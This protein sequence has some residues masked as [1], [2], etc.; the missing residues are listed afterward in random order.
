MFGCHLSQLWLSCKQLNNWINLIIYQ[1]KKRWIVCISY[2]VRTW[3]EHCD[4]I[5]TSFIYGLTIIEY[6]ICTWRT[7]FME[8]DCKIL[9]YSRLVKAAVCFAKSSF[10]ANDFFQKRK[11]TFTVK[12]KKISNSTK[13]RNG[14]SIKATFCLLLD[15]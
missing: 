8:N 7:P 12:V 14:T 1:F 10:L 6:Y 9:N 2:L 15:I 4:D 11:N 5:D 3:Q 13:R